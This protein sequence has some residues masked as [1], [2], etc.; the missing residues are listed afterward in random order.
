MIEVNNITEFIC[1]RCDGTGYEPG[2]DLNSN[3]LEICGKCFGRKKL[4]WI[5]KLV[6]KKRPRLYIDDILINVRM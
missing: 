2:Q 1:D 5:E 3:E 6:G 4:D